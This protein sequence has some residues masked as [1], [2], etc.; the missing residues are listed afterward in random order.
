MALLKCAACDTKLSPEAKF[1]PNC[2]AKLARFEG[3]KNT[4]GAFLAGGLMLAVLVALFPILNRRQ[5]NF[6]EN[7]ARAPLTE[8]DAARRVRIAE[9]MRQA[10]V[11]RNAVTAKPIP[12]STPE[13]ILSPVL[14]TVSKAQ[15]PREVTLR[16]RVIFTALKKD[17]SP[18]SASLPAGAIVNLTALSADAVFLENK[19]YSA[20]VK[21]EATDVMQRI[22]VANETPNA[23]QETREKGRADLREEE[24]R[25]IAA[26]VLQELGTVSKAELPKTVV[27]REAVTFT[28]SKKS[29]KNLTTSLPVGTVVALAAFTPD[30]LLL[31]NREYT[32]RVKP[33]ATDLAE[34]IRDARQ[35]KL[36][37]ERRTLER[38]READRLGLRWQYKE[39]AAEMD[40]GTVKRALV[41]SQNEFEFGFPY[42]GLQRASLELRMHPKNG[43][44]AILRVERGHFISSTGDGEVTVRFDRG[45]E[46]TFSV[47]SSSDYRTT[48]LFIR[49]YQRFLAGIRKAKLVQIE[50]E[51]YQETIRVFEFDVSGLKW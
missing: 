39:Y 24:S 14:A 44:D 8:T 50:A 36:D 9:T 33:E 6:S 4:D 15:W 28:L 38:E 51:F 22:H 49:D 16:E 2:G 29:A 27:L 40:R 35:A 45:K 12:A 34:R 41:R 26:A 48:V 20:R 25:R 32:A 10:E 19:G 21:P 7:T 31:E 47:S 18:T 42:Q 30:V 37:G 46:L 17:A 43:N 5:Q 1:C 11:A 13:V 3:E 23:T